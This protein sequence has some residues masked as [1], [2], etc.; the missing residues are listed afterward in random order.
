MMRLQPRERGW[1]WFGLKVHARNVPLAAVLEMHVLPK[2]YVG[3]CR[4]KEGEV[5]VCGLFRRRGSTGCR[6]SDHIRD[7]MVERIH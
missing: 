3:L 2:G 4:L 7:T 5:N 6:R 1:R